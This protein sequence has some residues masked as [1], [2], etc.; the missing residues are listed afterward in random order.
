ME[1]KLI[2]ITPLFNFL[3]GTLTAV[4][5]VNKS[6]A[7]NTFLLSLAFIRNQLLCQFSVSHTCRRFGRIL[8]QWFAIINTFS[9]LYRAW[10][11]GIKYTNL[12]MK[13][14]CYFL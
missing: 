9:H 7:S 10:N 6:T 13:A 8:L 11:S 5:S 14:F 1:P 3:A 12:S 4:S 2:I